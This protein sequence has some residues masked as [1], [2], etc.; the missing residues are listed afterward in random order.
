MNPVALL[1]TSDKTGIIELARTLVDKYQFTIVSSGGTAETLKQANIPVIKVSD[2]TGAPE[3]LGGRV[4]TLHPKVHGGILARLGLQKDLED[5]EKQNILPIALVVVNLYPFTQTIAKSGVT[6]EEAIEQI[7]IGGPTLIRAAAKNHEYVAVLSDPIQYS[8]YLEEMTENNGKTSLEFRRSLAVEAFQHTQSYD[9]AI[10]EYLVQNLA[11]QDLADQD[12]VQSSS[13]S[14]ILEGENPQPLRYGENPHQKATWYQL[15]KSGWSSAT[16]FQGKELS[17]NNLLDLEAARAIIAEFIDDDNCDPCAVIVKHNNPCGVAIA[18]NLSDAYKKAFNA[19]S[20]SAFGGI[21]AFNQAVDAATA[22]ALVTTFLECIVAP[23]YDPQ[24]LEILKSK[25]NLRVLELSDFR[26]GEPK[27]VK[28]IAGGILVQ[29]ADNVPVDVSTWE[30]VTALK[31][32]AAELAEMLF[33]WKVCRH[34]KS[35][36]IV[37]TSDRITIGVGAG[38]MNRVGSA[39]IALAQ[40]KAMGATLASDGFFPFDDTVKLVGAAGIKFIVQ[41]GGSLRDQDSIQAADDLGLIMAITHTRHF[42]H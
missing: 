32:T 29:Q 20:I 36:A 14:F 4:K 35:N 10:S 5:L 40:L 13:E 18:P 28:V 1:S 8:S 41:P 9:L 37:I 27:T 26:C 33:A 39:Q 11:S 30:I 12:F 3:I 2:Y 7:D 34:V 17:Y 16:Q 21:V 24:A 31:P 25:P 38:Q 6:L 42:L 15:Q 22:E 19:D 23:S